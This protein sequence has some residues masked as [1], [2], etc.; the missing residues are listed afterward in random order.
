MKRSVFND[1]HEAFRA[2]VRAFYADEVVPEYADWERAGAPPWHF[3]TAAGK[4]GLLGIQAPEEFGGGGQDSFLFNVI[5]TE[6]SQHAGI[7][8]GGLRVHTDIA[9]PYFLHHANHQQQSRWLPRLIS[10]DAV[11]ALA[12]SE[13]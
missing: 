9:M 7:A 1:D 5:L 12:M 13:P 8:L 10:G 4:L 11:A 3:W 2:T 6:E